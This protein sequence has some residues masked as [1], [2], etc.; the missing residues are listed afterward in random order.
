MG[1]DDVIFAGRGFM[2][3][4]SPIGPVEPFLGQP[5]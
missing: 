3:L 1:F 5:F 2:G 4:N